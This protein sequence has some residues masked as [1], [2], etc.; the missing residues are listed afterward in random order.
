MIY[1]YL[2]FLY[3]KCEALDAFKIYKAKVEK[4]LG[5][6]IKI[7]KSNRGGEYYGR[8]IERGQLSSPFAR[9]L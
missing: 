3:D 2:F 4:Q 1:I 8:Y 7:V 5:T 9:F 6:Q